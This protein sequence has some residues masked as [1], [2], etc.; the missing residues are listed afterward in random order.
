[1]TDDLVQRLRKLSW[2]KDVQAIADEAADR[3]EAL[4]VALQEIYHVHAPVASE[5]ARRVL[6]EKA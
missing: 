3:I 6:E 2:D 4:E 1:M 5:V